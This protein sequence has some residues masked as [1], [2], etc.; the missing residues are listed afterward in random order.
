M[1]GLVLVTIFALAARLSWAFDLFSHFRLQYAVLALAL[2]P[3]ALAARARASAALL[4]ALALV[5]GWALEDLWLG[6]AGGPA[7]SGVPL[8]IAS[9]NVLNANPTPERVLDFVRRSGADVVVLVDARGKRWR[10]VLRAIGKG[11]PY[12]APAGWQA[13]AP[14]ILFS[15]RPIARNT[16]IHPPAGRRPYLAADLVTGEGRLAVVGVHPSSPS[17]R[18]PTDSHARNLQLDHLARLVEGATGPVVLAGDFNTTRWSPYFEDFVATAGL[19]NAADGRGYVAT[20]PSWFWPLQIPIDHIL[21]KGTIA[22]EGLRRG[23]PIGSDHYPILADLRV[24][25]E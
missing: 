17:P 3:L 1:A 7:A 15:R 11:Y 19:R 6:E 14:V 20:W 23:P 5:H 18:D 2:L 4:A 10:G 9:A 22:V 24:A 25:A 8:R 13:G 16:V 21:V 12:R